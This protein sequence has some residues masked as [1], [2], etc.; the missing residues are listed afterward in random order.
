MAIELYYSQVGQNGGYLKFAITSGFSVTRAVLLK[1]SQVVLIFSAAQYEV[2]M[3]YVPRAKSFV[4]RM[5]H[6]MV[7]G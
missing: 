1:F 2:V 4:S 7:N 3:S 6:F 5:C